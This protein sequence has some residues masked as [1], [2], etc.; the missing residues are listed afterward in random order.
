MCGAL[1]SGLAARPEGLGLL[2]GWLAVDAALGYVFRQLRALKGPASAGQVDVASSRWQRLRDVATTAGPRAISA[3]TGSGVVLVLATYVGRQSL[4]VA[5]VGLFAGALATLLTVDD[6]PALERVLAGLHVSAAWL[7][8]H[9]ALAPLTGAS[10]GLALVAGLA[11]YARRLPAA[12]LGGARWLL[13]WAWALWLL[14]SIQGRQPL[15]T[16][17]VAAGA[18]AELMN[19]GIDRDA[20][21]WLT[22]VGQ[23][24]S[25]WAATVL[26]AL[27]STRWG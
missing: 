17:V 18:L 25:W 8:G 16:A 26:V 6:R 1:A 27:A 23:R 11:T 5:A 12:R 21:G 7:M 20:A 24:A 15:V 13:R 14:A 10:W 4:L 3:L 9:A 22:P 2:A 19:Q